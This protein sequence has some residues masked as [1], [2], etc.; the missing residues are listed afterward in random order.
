[1]STTPERVL[2]AT[3]GSEDAALAGKAAADICRGS[4]A[5]LHV[6][7]AWQAVPTARMKGFMRAEL[8][9]AG[10]ERLEAEVER[11][12]SS[13]TSP[14]GRYLVE[15]RPADEVLDLA[16]RLGADLIVVGSR[17]LGPVRRLA[18]GSVAEGIIQHASCAVLVLRGDAAS[19]PPERVVFA[20]DGSSSAR[21][22]GDLAASLCAA[23]GARGL[24]VHAYPKLPEVDAEGRESNARLADDD[25][26]LQE[27]ALM[28]RAAELEKLLGSR[29]KVRLAVGDATAYVL[30]ASEAETPERTLVA[31][32]SRGLGA[33]GR[34]R[35]G[36]V[37]AK[38]LRA[39]RGPVLVH[40]PS[41]GAG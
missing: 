4:G 22:A 2:L 28:Q 23:Y 29:P 21:A 5:E 32:G 14:T 40:P 24:L 38:T 17:G 13:G 25:M 10:R 34:M 9:R 7:H 36:S 19:W 6:V 27:R 39:A 12:E 26:R 35:L 37:S 33:M 31:V 20:D 18:L 15:G 30:E 16:A 11:L 41:G 1:M 8:E 3:D